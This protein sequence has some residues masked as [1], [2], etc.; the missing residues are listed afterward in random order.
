MVRAAEVRTCS[1][2][3]DDQRKTALQVNFAVVAVSLGTVPPQLQ[4]TASIRSFSSKMNRDASRTVAIF[5]MTS[6]IGRSIERRL[7]AAGY[8]VVGVSRRSGL[9]FDIP[10]HEFD[11]ASHTI[12]PPLPKT[13]I[14][15]S[16]APLPALSDILRAVDTEVGLERVIAF[17]TTGIFTKADSSSPD[18]RRFVQAQLEGEKFLAAWS[19]GNGIGWT[20]LRPTM[21]YGINKDLNVAFIR[22]IFR[23]FHCF[24]LPIGATGV[25]QPVHVEDLAGACLK[26]LAHTETVNKA[27]NLGGGEVLLYEDM[28]RRIRRADGHSSHLIPIPRTIYYLLIHMARLFMGL[29]HLRTEMVDRMYADL[30]TDNSIANRD[31]GYDPRPFDPPLG[32]MRS[33]Q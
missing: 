21:I 33:D 28:V 14:L 9:T 4:R 3:P 16:L 25:R 32:S 29:A 2:T 7:S 10:M 26:L 24:P 30:V 8:S 6:Q 11:P 27:Y 22:S 20:L 23:R 13:S 1:L 17:G 5:G 19:D 18:E 12:T 15:I 31:F